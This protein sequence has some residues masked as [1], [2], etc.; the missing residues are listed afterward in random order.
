MNVVEKDDKPYKVNGLFVVDIL[1]SYSL[2]PMW[3]E[4]VPERHY[5]TLEVGEKVIDIYKDIKGWH[6]AKPKWG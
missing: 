6:S 4:G 3:W 5:F 1:D 2:N